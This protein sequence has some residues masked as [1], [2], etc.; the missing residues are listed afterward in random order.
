MQQCLSH[1]TAFVQMFMVHH[2]HLHMTHVSFSASVKA[3]PVTNPNF[4]RVYT[5]SLRVGDLDHLVSQQRLQCAARCSARRTIKLTAC[6]HE[7]KILHCTKECLCNGIVSVNLEP[8]ENY[9]I[10][11]H[12]SVS[13]QQGLKNPDYIAQIC[14]PL[15]TALVWVDEL[16]ECDVGHWI[17]FATTCR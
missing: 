15:Q 3:G 5:P 6:Q 10:Y 13:S 16:G 17:M 8:L 12:N 4:K 1:K 2:P 14:L 9:V 11:I 7:N